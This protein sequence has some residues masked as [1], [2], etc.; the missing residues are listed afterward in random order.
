[1]RPIRPPLRTDAPP[2]ERA[3]QLWTYRRDLER[4]WKL[5]PLPGAG[6]D[7]V[8]PLSPRGRVVTGL[9]RMLGLADRGWR[10]AC[11][12]TLL[13]LS[14]RFAALPER[15]DGL[16]ILHLS[17]LHYPPAAEDYAT[18]VSDLVSGL[19][20]DLCVLTGDYRFGRRTQPAAAM[21]RLA[22][23]IPR[24]HARHGVFATLGN[25]DLC[26]MVGDLRVMG[27][28]VL[29][30]EGL[31]VDAD[32]LP[33]WIA[34]VD[35]PHM[36]RCADAGAAM[37]GAPRDA[38]KLFLA[39]APESYAEAAALGA[40]L[41]LCGHTHAGQVRFPRIGALYANARCPIAYAAGEWRHGS[42]QGYTSAGLGVTEVPVR[43]RCPPE[44]AVITLQRDDRP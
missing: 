35:D 22:D 13:D 8:L 21:A 3:A 7:G 1:M 27:I 40:D 16:R 23:L 30:N 36:F 26:E 2:A 6:K 24:I 17:D 12:P 10:N 4:Y 28:T 14:F 9:L 25:H 18:A 29:V 43:F 41:Y 44:A 31:Q 32:G 19:E 42:M 15:L 5:Q 34:G 33:L 38:F 39:H 11:T 37:A 20:V